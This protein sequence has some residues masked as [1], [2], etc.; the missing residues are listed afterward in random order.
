MCAGAAATTVDCTPNTRRLEGRSLG[1]LSV[2]A[3]CWIARDRRLWMVCLVERLEGG[4]CVKRSK[5][6][7][8][9]LEA[10]CKRLGF[11]ATK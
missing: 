7:V 2:I 1:L 4:L 5:N 8:T 9:D 3:G 11:T 6:V 10:R